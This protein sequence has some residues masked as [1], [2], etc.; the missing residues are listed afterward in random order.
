M[1]VYR[2]LQVKEIQHYHNV[3]INYYIMKKLVTLISTEGKTVEEITKQTWGAFKKYRKLNKQV[4]KNIDT[5]DTDKNFR[6]NKVPALLKNKK[7]KIVD[8][9]LQNL[10][11]AFVI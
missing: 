10:D 3:E 4:E 11:K 9:T 2:L 7:N 1:P 6:N 5:N 8:V